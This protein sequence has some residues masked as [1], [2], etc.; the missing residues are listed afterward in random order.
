MAQIKA[1][2]NEQVVQLKQFMGLN[3]NPDGDTKLK[4]GE[5]A[6]MRNFCVTRDGN[7]RKRPG[8]RTFLTL[9]EDKPIICLWNGMI[10]KRHYVLAA[11]DNKLWNLWDDEVGEWKA[12]EI[13]AVDTSKSVHVFGFNEIAYILDGNKY[14]QYDGEELKEVEGY[15]PIVAITVPPNGGGETYEQINKLSNKRRMWISPDGKGTKFLLPEE[16]I[17]AVEYLKYTKDDEPLTEGYTVDLAEASVTFGWNST[18]TFT[19][20]GKKK[21][22]Q[23]EATSIANVSVTVNGTEAEVKLSNTYNTITFAE[24]PANGAAIVVAVTTTLERGVNTIEICWSVSEDFRSQVSAMRYSE[25]YNGTTDSRVFIYGDGSNEAFYSGLDYIG[26]PRADYFPDLNEMAVGEAN[27]PITAMIRHF[28]RMIAFKH[29]SAWAVQFS[30]STLADG[31]T[32]PAFYVTPINKVIGNAALGQVCMV[33]NNPRTIFGKDLYEWKSSSYYNS[34][35]SNDERQAQRISD[36]IHEALSEF[37]LEKCICFD[38]NYKQEYFVCYEDRMLVHN[39]AA[40]A[41]YEYSNLRAASMLSFFGRTY[42]G[43]TDGKFKCF[44]ELYLSDDG[45]AIDAYWESGSMSFGSDY[46]R[47]YAAQLWVGIKPQDSSE[48][49]VTVQTDRKSTYTE[50]LVRSALSSFARWNF[51]DLSFKLNR[52]PQMTRLKIKAK[53][54]VFYKLIFTTDTSDSTVT[55]LAADIRVRTTGYSK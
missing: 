15:V 38:D 29:N 4:F 6:A 47:K 53:K 1:T 5:A 44:D 27:T 26:E 46:M 8:T 45:E 39:Y 17:S 50:K 30:L 36:R 25:L 33:L 52:K 28:S 22:F 9:S 23:L 32:V 18:E 48:V 2:T 35:L 41:W 55:V 37:E 20:D 51:K 10:H 12:A 3:Q 31:I 16:N 21:E 54:F 43:T 24:A 7:L 11:C 42:I 13:G 40:N 34:N 49:W 19:G 14:Q